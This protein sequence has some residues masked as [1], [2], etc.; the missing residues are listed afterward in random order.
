MKKFVYISSVF[1]LFFYNFIIAQNSRLQLTKSDIDYKLEEI[2]SNTDISNSEK[3]KA[4]LIL[5]SES[6]KL[7]Y[8]RGILLSGDFLMTI[9]AYQYKYKEIVELGNQLKKI[10]QYKKEDPTGIVSSI[11][12]RCGLALAYLGLDE[13]SKKDF[14]TAIKYVETIQDTDRKQLRLTQCYMDLFTYYNNRY[15]QFLHNK[16]YKDSTLYYLQ[17]A[18]KTGKSIDDNS[19]QISKEIKYTEIISTYMRLGIFYLEHS[20]EKGN[21]KLAEWNLIEALKT[22]ENKDYNVSPARGKTILLNQLS[23]LYMEKKDYSKSI[24]YAERALKMEK[25]YKRPTA[26]VESFE[27]LAGCYAAIGEKEKSKYYMQ[28]YTV[29]KDSIHIA[30]QKNVDATMKNI[31]EN[32]NND[33]EETLNKVLIITVILVII[34]SIT[35]YILW[36]RKSHIIHKKYE[37]ITTKI[38]NEKTPEQVTESKESKSKIIIADETTKKLLHK[39]NKFERSKKYLEKDI[40]LPWLASD[41]N[42]NTKYLSEIIKVYKEKSFTNYINGL[43][44]NYLLHKLVAEPKYREYK[45]EYL[46]DESGFASPQVF[47]S[48]FKKETG[49]TPSYFISNLKNEGTNQTTE[50]RR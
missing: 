29:L 24:E 39:L 27:F 1:F 41:L 32:I 12:R 34:A 46:A 18:L 33:H 19:K 23:W 9:Y 30:N 43:R 49:F 44:I 3:E 4:L 2:N 17:E 38:R 7:A 25:Q 15:R 45:I 5:K 47:G 21:L 13:E 35:L 10:T 14:E 37:E 6:E 16:I 22:Y 40:S 28:R 26:R 31:V 8:E 36:K 48:A 42:T 20:N 50:N 11:Y